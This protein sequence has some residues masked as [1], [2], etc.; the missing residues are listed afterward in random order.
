MLVEEVICYFIAII[1]TVESHVEQPGK[2]LQQ[3]A[4]QGQISIQVYAFLVHAPGIIGSVVLQ[5]HGVVKT[6]GI[7]HAAF[8][9]GS[10]Q[11]AVC[12]TV[13]THAVAVVIAFLVPPFVV[14][15]QLRVHFGN[16]SRV[17]CMREDFVYRPAYQRR[18]AVAGIVF[19]R[20]GVDAVDNHAVRL[21]IIEHGADVVLCQFR[22]EFSGSGT[23]TPTVP[24][25]ETYKVA[26]G[27][28]RDNTFVKQ[29]AAMR[30]PVGNKGGDGFH[31]DTVV[32]GLHVLAQYLGQ[33]TLPAF[34]IGLQCFS[35]IVE[36]G[37]DILQSGGHLFFRGEEGNGYMD[38]ISGTVNKGCVVVF[39]PGKCHVG[40]KCYGHA[41]SAG[42]AGNDGVL[43]YSNGDV[44]SPLTACQ[45]QVFRFIGLYAQEGG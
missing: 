21:L 5:H 17:A 27:V 44:F 14:R 22:V 6:N 33:I 8:P 11:C 41:F 7:V 31:G 23:E 24:C 39:R 1:G 35:G 36:Q 40:G 10:F 16:E 26:Y 32:F 42:V 12:C 30:A 29:S 4:L 18:F 2:L 28:A 37:R 34:G 38:G 15:E 9:C 25:P 13:L 43:L 3:F 45:K 20:V 19:R